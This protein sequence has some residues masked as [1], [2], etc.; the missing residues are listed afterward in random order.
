MS[1]PWKGRIPAAYAIRI[2]TDA[3]HLLIEIPH[4]LG[5]KTRPRLPVP[6]ASHITNSPALRV[7]ELPTF[8]AKAFVTLDVYAVPPPD[9]SALMA[10][11]AISVL[12]TAGNRAARIAIGIKS[13]VLVSFGDHE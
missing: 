12:F 6:R 3:V 8:N 10:A 5:K 13:F 9:S 7:L 11:D 4:F 1:G 2:I